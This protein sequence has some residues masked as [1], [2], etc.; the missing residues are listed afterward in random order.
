MLADIII[1]QDKI[2]LPTITYNIMLRYRPIRSIDILTIQL[3]F[4]EVILEL[5]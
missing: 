3:L 2:A 4:P 1:V 5:E